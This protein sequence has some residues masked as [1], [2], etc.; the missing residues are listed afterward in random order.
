M[1]V[2]V[3]IP[4]C[5][6]FVSIESAKTIGGPKPYKACFILQDAVNRTVREATVYP[7]VFKTGNDRL[8]R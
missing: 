8:G 7:E 4:V 1:I 2:L 6:Q 5:C 3:L